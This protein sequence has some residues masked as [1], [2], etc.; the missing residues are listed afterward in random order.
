LPENIIQVDEQD[1]AI[2]P[3][4]RLVAHQGDGVLHRGLMVVVKNSRDEVLLTQRSDARPD[5]NFPPPFP[6]FWDITMA[7]H[8]RWGQTDYVSQMVVE[9]KEELGISV[10][11]AE[12][13]YA[14]KFQY[15][16]PDPTYPNPSAP[17]GFRLS[18][19]EICGVGVARTEQTPRLNEVELRSYMWVKDG[20]VRERIGKEHLKLAPWADIMM[21]KFPNVIKS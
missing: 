6:G 13:E 21:Q 7:G 3:I 15:H 18:E 17:P 5:L 8:P 2:G 14:G 4:E 16:S 20:Q 9:L 1:R 19:F 10:R 12:I 11:T